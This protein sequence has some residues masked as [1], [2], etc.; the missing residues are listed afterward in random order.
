ML[1][2]RWSELADKGLAL[3]IAA[4][5]LEGARKA[6]ELKLRFS[7]AVALRRH[8]A[9][10]ERQIYVFT[11]FAGVILRAVVEINGDITIWHVG[12]QPAPTE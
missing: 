12:I 2:V 9:F 6:I 8:P 1:Q 11:L 5:R 7:G 3:C 4:D 10:I